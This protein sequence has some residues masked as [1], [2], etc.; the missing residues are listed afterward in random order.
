MRL[1]FCALCGER[2]RDCLEHHHFIPKVRGGTDDE[3]NMFTVCGS[4]HG[5]I[6]DIPRPLRLGDL[7]IEGREKAQSRN[8]SEWRNVAEQK[9]GAAE[10]ADA[11]A[12]AAERKEAAIRAAA[13]RTY[14]E[15]WPRC[16]RQPW[17]LVE[18]EIVLQRDKTFCDVENW[19]LATDGIQWVVQRRRGEQWEA[20]SFVRSSRDVLTRCL[21]EKGAPASV[22][23]H[24]CRGLPA[25]FDGW[26]ATPEFKTAMTHVS[27]PV[28]HVSE[29]MEGHGEPA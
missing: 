25:T 18:K 16:R 15:H 8:S 11:A 28:T 24:L 21:R 2:D 26:K 14:A 3:S 19:A 10:R 1:D 7:I 5:R 4:C 23:K 6:H 27:V 9:A 17:R 13:R 12:D 20:L 22:I 29:P